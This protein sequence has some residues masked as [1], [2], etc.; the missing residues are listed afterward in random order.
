MLPRRGQMLISLII[1]TG[2]FMILAHALFTLVFSSYETISFTR[3]RITARHFAQEKMELIRNLPFDDV[4]TI[5]GIP[6]GILEQT[7]RRIINGLTYLAKISIVYVDDP[8]DDVAP[9]DLLA[10]DYKRVRVDV[11]WE[12]LAGSETNPVTIISDIAPRGIETTTGGGTLSILVFNALGQPVGGAN[13]QIVANSVTPPVN[14]TLQTNAS[15]RVFLPGAPVCVS[16]YK[17]AVTK[18]GF[19]TDR[20]YSVTEVANPTKPHQTVLE[21]QLTEVSFAIDR[22]GSIR[23]TTTSGRETGFTPLPNV[24]FQ[25]RGEKTIG[26]DTSDLPV[27]K[28]NKNLTTDSLGILQIDN[29]EWDSYTFSLPGGSLYVIS[30]SNPIISF[31]LQPNINLD[32][33]VSLVNKTTNS[34]LTI[35]VDPNQNPIASVSAKLSDGAGFEATNSSGLLGNPDFGQAFFANLSD[36]IYNLV[37]TVS[38][39]LDSNSNINVKG[40]TV[41]K[42]IL[43]PQ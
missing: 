33:S 14:L 41:E 24:S 8:F 31:Q 28:Y 25:L 10:N 32:F 35:F 38:G 21:S 20:T 29:L 30:G 5:G 37:A 39:F 23:V 19:S 1:S 7:E 42:I 26:T 34:L 9:V 6:P 36:R 17:I 3:A 13:V 16:C 12:G 15:G 18:E 27:Y 2:V 4:G 40:E 43:T 22:L 11:S